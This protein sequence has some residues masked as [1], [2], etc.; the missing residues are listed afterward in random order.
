MKINKNNLKGMT[1]VEVIVAMTIFVLSFGAVLTILSGA[2]HQTNRNRRRDIESGEQAAA[3][4]KKSTQDL[5]QFGHNTFNITF[6]GPY[7]ASSVVNLFEANQRTFNQDFG[8]QYKTFQNGALD[9]LDTV[10]PNS[11]EYV[12]TIDNVSNKEITVKVDISN[13]TIFEGSSGSYG[14]IHPSR[15]YTRT[16]KPNSS[17]NFGYKTGSYN[18]SDLK[19]KFYIDN[20]SI[21]SLPNPANI[22]VNTRKV[23][24][25]LNGT[26]NVVLKYPRT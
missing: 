10:N 16:I 24:V 18:T 4:G 9:G 1:L 8:F 26:S 19:M 23:S 22:D 13:G 11:D 5:T 25:T 15:I 21:N 12:F 14:Y 3:V 2:F 6:S 17:I 7:N 20:W